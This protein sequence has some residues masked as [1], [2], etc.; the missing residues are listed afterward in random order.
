MDYSAFYRQINKADDRL[1]EISRAFNDLRLRTEDFSSCL[2]EL[3]TEAEKIDIKKERE[4]F[5]NV[6]ECYADRLH[7]ISEQC[8]DLSGELDEAHHCDFVDILVR[9]EE[10]ADEEKKKDFSKADN[11]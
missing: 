11:N 2:E 6:L 3:A 1:I 5:K 10:M 8:D 9:A 7:A 4:I